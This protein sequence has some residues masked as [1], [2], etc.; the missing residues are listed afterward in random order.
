MEKSSENHVLSSLDYRH[1]IQPQFICAREKYIVYLRKAEATEIIKLPCFPQR[2]KITKIFYLYATSVSVW[3]TF[4][5]RSTFFEEIYFVCIWHFKTGSDVHDQIMRHE[6]VYEEGNAFPKRNLPKL[7]VRQLSNVYIQ[8]L[9]TFKWNEWFC[10]WHKPITSY[11]LVEKSWS[12]YI[13]NISSICHLQ[14]W[15]ITPEI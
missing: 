5:C 13:C 8:W 10:V 6:Y 14:Y 15:L 2:R 9:I 11:P 4:C 1:K 7:S 3:S 12:V